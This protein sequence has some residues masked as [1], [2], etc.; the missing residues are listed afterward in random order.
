MENITTFEQLYKVCKNKNK[1]IFE[2]AIDYE[3]SLGEYSEYQ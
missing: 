3:V 1:K 2:A